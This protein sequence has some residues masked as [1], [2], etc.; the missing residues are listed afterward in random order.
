MLSIERPPRDVSLYR[1]CMSSEVKSGIRLAKEP[2]VVQSPDILRDNTF[3]PIER[4]GLTP[5]DQ[6]KTRTPGVA[7]RR[8]RST[9]NNDAKRPIY[10]LSAPSGIRSCIA[11]RTS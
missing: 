9:V 10:G 4:E 1:V 8:P 6:M 5:Y 11:G 7:P 3:T 2:R